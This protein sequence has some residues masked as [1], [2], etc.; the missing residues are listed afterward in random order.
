MYNTNYNHESIATT[1]ILITNLGT[2]DAPT[3]QALKKYLGEF[4]WDRRVVSIPR[5]LWWLILNG[6]IL[7][8]R[9]KKSAEAYKKVWTEDGSPLLQIALKQKEKLQKHL[10]GISAAPVKV[11]L[12]MRYGT[13]SIESALNE[14]KAANAQRIIVLPLY[15][16]HSSATTAST[17]DAIGLAMKKAF[18]VPDLRFVSSYHD[19]PSFI[20][21]LA[22]QIKNYWNKN[23]QAEKLFFSFHG[24]PARTLP[25]GDPY[26][27]H[28][29]K[30]ARLVAEQLGLEKDQWITAFQSRFGK[31]EWLKPYADETLIK[32][33]QS[34]LKSVDV[35]CPGFSADCL[36]TLEE[37]AIENKETFQNAGGGEYRYIPALN[38]SDEHITALTN[39]IQTHTGDWPIWDK[40]W[41][42]KIAQK[43]A[44]KTSQRASELSES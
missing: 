17:F 18:W 38:D 5:P 2:P 10:D 6:V 29:H 35:V 21:A 36:E 1:G 26:F 19:N 25:A 42:M 27:C 44:K 43:N 24:M 13:P 7:T 34:K 40:N 4:L 11:A 28:C 16:Q 14:L 32:L 9:P 31:E 22:Q 3:P 8:T 23:G 30:T 20:T 41:S 37:M 33:G 39:V 15:P 12:G